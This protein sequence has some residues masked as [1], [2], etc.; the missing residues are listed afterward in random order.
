MSPAYTYDAVDQ[1]TGIT[2]S[3]IYGVLADYD[4]TYDAA[5]HMTSAATPDGTVDYTHDNAGQLTGANN[6]VLPD[7]SYAYDA[8]GNRTGGA[9]VIGQDNRLT[10]DGTYTYAYDDEGN[11]VLRTD[12]AAT[13]SAVKTTEYAWDYR[14]RLS[15]HVAACY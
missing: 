10:S 12:P 6:S 1:V 11:L 3:S 14:N 13:G 8:G 15:R 2:H 7:E 9:I 4:W 5:G